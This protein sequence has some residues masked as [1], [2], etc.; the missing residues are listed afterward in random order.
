MGKIEKLF[1]Q[2]DNNVMK[3]YS[4]LSTPNTACAVDVLKSHIEHKRV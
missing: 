3:S 4:R 1:K 2:N